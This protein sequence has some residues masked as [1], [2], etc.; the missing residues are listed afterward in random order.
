MFQA[1]GIESTFQF[2]VV[3]D[4]AG[5]QVLLPVLARDPI[6]RRGV[7]GEVRVV[8]VAVELEHAQRLAQLPVVAEFVGEFRA[9]GLRL[10]VDEI[11]LAA[12]GRIAPDIGRAAIHARD[13]AIRRSVVAAVFVLH[14]P[15]QIG[16]QLPAHRGREQLAIATHAIAEAVFVHVAHVQAKADVFGRIGAEVGVK[17][18][19]VLA[20]ALGFDC[21]AAAEFRQFAH[22]VDDPALAATAVQH[23]RRT[24]EHIDAFDVVQVAHVLAVVADTVQI[25]VIAGVEA[26]DAQAIEAGVGATADVGD[27][28]ERGAQIVGAVVNDVRGFDRI[29]GLRDIAYRRVGAGRGVGFLHAGVIGFRFG[30][31]GS[32]R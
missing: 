7:A 16:C 31:D 29:N 4:V 28:A 1:E 20:A 23:C 13:S 26:T 6:G 5:G 22:S 9:Q 25:E 8:E 11:V 12:V 32:G 24:F 2:N 19:Q 27:A 18:A 30:A 14:Q 15:V 17:T 10:V 3:V 21:R